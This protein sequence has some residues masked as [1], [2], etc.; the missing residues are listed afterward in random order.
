MGSSQPQCKFGPPDRSRVW[1]RGE[2][3]AEGWYASHGFDVIG[4]N[5]RCRAGEID[6]VARKGRLTV[7]CEVK[8]RSSA[9]FGS[10]ADAVGP[11]KQ[12]RARRLAA[13]WFAAHDGAEGSSHGPDLGQRPD[14]QRPDGRRPDGRRQGGP[15][16][17]DVACVLDGVVEVIEGAF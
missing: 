8:A 9:R 5:W 3:L 2:E 12:M 13:L 1:R 6:I 4:R 7:F 16:R 17:F 11:S 15:V 10:P 14:G